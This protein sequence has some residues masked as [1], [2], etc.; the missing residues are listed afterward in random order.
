M[1]KNICQEAEDYY[2]FGDNNDYVSPGS[3][4]RPKA[5]KKSQAVLQLLLSTNLGRVFEGKLSQLS[6]GEVRKTLEKV[7]DA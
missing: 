3:V 1:S 7:A 5:I 2:D 6:E 4:E